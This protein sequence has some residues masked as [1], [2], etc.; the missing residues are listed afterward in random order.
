RGIYI[1]AVAALLAQT[2][3]IDLESPVLT[4]IVETVMSAR[5]A[6][7]A[8]ALGWYAYDFQQPQTAAEWFSLALRW[9]ADLEPAAYGLMVASNALG[10]RSTVE[11]IRAQWNA[12]SAR[13][14]EFGR[15]NQSTA[16]PIPVARPAHQA[17]AP[18]IQAAQ[19]IPAR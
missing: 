19:L 2:P 15:T 13:I 12:R 4:R 10:D 5:D 14:A 9:Q 3:R 18:T 11:S 8:Q 1:D 16:P 7:V 17:A 6:N